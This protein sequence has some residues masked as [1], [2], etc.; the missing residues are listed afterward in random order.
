MPSIRIWTL[1]S[2]NDARAVKR[3]VNRYQRGNTENIVEAE[4]GGRGAKE[5]LIE[6][7]EKI[8]SELN[9]NIRPKNINREKYREALSPEVAEHIV[10]NRETLQR[11]NSL[12]KLGDVIGRFQ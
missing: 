6:F 11:N 4:Q 7:S 9:P 12:K 3:L 8:L 10:I 1:E 5:Y 2:D